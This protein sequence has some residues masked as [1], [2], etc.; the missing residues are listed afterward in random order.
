MSEKDIPSVN[1]VVDQI[2]DYMPNLLAGLIVF[3]LGLVVAWLG[4]KLVV[5]LLILSRIDRVM[6]R[7]GWGQAVDKGDVRHSL[8]AFLGTL[9]GGVIFLI[10]LDNAT[11]I[12]RLTVLSEMLERFVVLI[13]RLVASSII[14]LV[15][16]GIAA[17]ASKSVRRSLYQEE[18]ERARLVGRIV[19]SSIIVVTSAIALVQLDIAVGIV[20][21]AFFI[22]F[23]TIALT[24]VLA[25]GLG[26]KSAVE[27]M[28]KRRLRELD[29]EHEEEPTDEEPEK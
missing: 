18:F 14:M 3:V 10:F 25:F 27:V 6:V 9:T 5:R 26:S 28:W 7:L 23:G 21:G 2:G 1:D 29:A 19:F 13:P 8:F 4:A 22:A 12:W 24:V 15:G 17:A 16:W 11:V 20:T